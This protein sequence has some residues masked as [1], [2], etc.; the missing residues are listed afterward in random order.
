VSTTVAVVE[1]VSSVLV[2]EVVSS[3]TLV[4]SIVVVVEDISLFS[5]CQKLDKR[6]NNDLQN[7]TQ[8]PDKNRG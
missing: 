5:D 1:V 7:T 2:V 4:V 8:N 3:V 6:A